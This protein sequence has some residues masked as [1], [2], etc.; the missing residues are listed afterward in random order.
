MECLMKTGEGGGLYVK[1]LFCSMIEIDHNLIGNFMFAVLN[2]IFLVV[3]YFSFWTQL[4]T[5]TLY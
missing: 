2:Y 1:F 3:S 5:F 4:V